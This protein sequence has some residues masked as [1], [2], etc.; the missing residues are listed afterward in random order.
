M[1]GG[2]STVKI[3][4]PGIHR[5]LRG[6]SLLI[7]SIEELMVLSLQGVPIMNNQTIAWKKKFL[8]MEIGW[9]KVVSL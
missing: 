8:L 9:Y 6:K 5:I 7:F 1:I 3:F 2:K 4:K